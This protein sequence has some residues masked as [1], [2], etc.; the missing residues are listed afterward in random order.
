VHTAT[1]CTHT[2]GHPLDR[3]VALADLRQ[4]VHH[5]PARRLVLHRDLR[6]RVRG[7]GRSAALPPPFQGSSLSLCFFY[8]THGVVR[9]PKRTWKICS[10]FPPSMTLSTSASFGCSPAGRGRGVRVKGLGVRQL[11]PSSARMHTHTHTAGRG[12][13][14]GGGWSVRAHLHACA[15]AHMHARTHPPTRARTHPSPSAAAC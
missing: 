2:G 15:R 3:R 10:P 7:P 12:R 1:V 8:R 11:G 14:S 9:T 5:A 13:G 6:A 4:H